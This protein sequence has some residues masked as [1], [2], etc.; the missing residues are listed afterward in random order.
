MAKWGKCD[1]SEFE[2]LEKEF[3]KLAKTD[4]EKF[5]K[6]CSQRTCSNGCYQKLF[7]EHLLGKEPL[8]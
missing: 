8:K 7:L 1:F 2:K 3:E 6:R 4:V 5:C